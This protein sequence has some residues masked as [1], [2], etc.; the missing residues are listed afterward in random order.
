MEKSKMF[1]L[2]ACLIYM[3]NAVKKLKHLTAS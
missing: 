2:Y 1:S 3:P